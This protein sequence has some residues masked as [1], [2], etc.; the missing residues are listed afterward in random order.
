MPQNVSVYLYSGAEASLCWQCKAILLYFYVFL[1]SWGPIRVTY[2]VNSA[3]LR[4]FQRHERFDQTC[5]SLRM[6]SLSVELA[7]LLVAVMFV[8]SDPSGSVE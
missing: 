8:P 3:F 2:A 4:I 5:G 6:R 7:L 1:M